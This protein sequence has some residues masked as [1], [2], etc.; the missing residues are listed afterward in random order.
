[1]RLLTYIINRYLG[2]LFLVFLCTDYFAQDTIIMTNASIE[3]A[4]IKQITQAQIQYKKY[5]IPQGALY[6]VNKTEV[7]KIKYKDGRVD[8][9]SD[10]QI[11]DS[12]KPKGSITSIDYAIVR[13]NHNKLP[14]LVD[15]RISLKNKEQLYKDAN[16]LG[17]LSAHQRGTTKGIITFACFT[18][19]SLGV[20]DFDYIVTAGNPQKEFFIPPAGFA[21]FTVAFAAA[22]IG[23]NIK[24]RKKR[25]AFIKLY[26]E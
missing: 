13:K 2:F 15:D 23:I 21:F 8:V 9:Y 3:I 14:T 4:D 24:L 18:A 6:I 25:T 26:N 20:L 22:N 19:V 17:S 10:L 1:M 11:N 12:S 7:H 5:L 16:A